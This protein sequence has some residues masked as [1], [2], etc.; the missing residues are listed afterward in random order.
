MLWKQIYIRIFK[1]LK[2]MENFRGIT[3]ILKKILN[4]LLKDLIFNTNFLNSIK[5]LIKL[6]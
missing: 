4:F 1:K 5:S 2:P 6:L 3:N